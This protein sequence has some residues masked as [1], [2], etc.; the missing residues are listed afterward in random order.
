MRKE[1]NCGRYS[2]YGVASR[3]RRTRREWVCHGSIRGNGRT[4]GGLPPFIIDIPSEGSTQDTPGDNAK[5]DSLHHL[6]RCIFYLSDLP[7]LC[8]YQPSERIWVSRIENARRWAVE[9]SIVII[10]RQNLWGL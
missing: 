2:W 5:G 3:W 6:A 4:R 10:F 1:S 9:S 7:I 8:T